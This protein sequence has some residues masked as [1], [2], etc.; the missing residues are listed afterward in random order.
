MFAVN[1]LGHFLLTLLLLERLKSAGS[2]R[3]VTVA[4]S[5]YRRAELDLTVL[6]EHRD[7]A[8]GS[9]YSRLY[10]KY[11]NSKLCNILFTWELSRRLQGSG[12]TCYSLHP[13]L[14]RTEL[15]RHLGFWIRVFLMP[16]LYLFFMDPE[17]GAQTTLHCALEQ[18]IEHLSGHFFSRC[19]PQLDVRSEVKDD[20][21][22]R[23]W[24]LSEV[25]CGL[26]PGGGSASCW[27]T[28]F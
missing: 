18:G 23:L 27:D 15:G 21:A 12:V 16:F 8:L 13:G 10:R 9:T 6:M 11:C 19:S 4:S 2:A 20:D 1:H 24:E 17:S 7:S 28:K 14:I 5:R 3:V 22:V 25:F 26:E